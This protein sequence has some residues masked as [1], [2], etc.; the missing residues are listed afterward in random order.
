VSA[1]RL[2]SEPARAPIFC[3]PGPN[4]ADVVDALAHAGALAVPML[5]DPFRLSL[6]E[7]A[8]ASGFRA[9]RARVGEGNRLVYQRMEVCG[10]FPAG[11]LFHVLSAAFQ[12]IWDDFQAQDSSNPFEERL[13]FNDLMLQRYSVGEM[14]ITPHRDR[15][16]YRNLVCLFVLEGEGRFYIC[17]DRSGRGAREILHAPGDV[18][19]MRAPGF[20][21]STERPFHYVR[22]IQSPR[23][24][25]GLRHQRV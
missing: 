12:K 21:G 10:H 17:D 5:S 15:T 3:S 11:S 24:V 1:R 20:L 9:A 19:L 22:D 8:R 7:A 2:C 23:Y 4:L 18:L 13:L 14:G 25:F 16:A 6:L